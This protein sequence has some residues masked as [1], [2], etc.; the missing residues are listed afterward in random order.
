MCLYRIPICWL[1]LYILFKI[2]QRTTRP[3]RYVI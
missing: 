2:C 3:T 1:Q